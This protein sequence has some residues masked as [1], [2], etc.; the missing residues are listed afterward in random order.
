M[1]SYRWQA[2]RRQDQ[3]GAALL[4]TISFM[5]LAVL[6]L[7]LVVDTGR[8]YVEKRKLQRV[9]D[10]ATIEAN[11]RNG[12]CTDGTALTY[13][14]Q[15]ATRNGYSTNG[16][17]TITVTCGVLTTVA[18]VRTVQPPTGTQVNN[19]IK[20]VVTNN[21]RASLIAGG[22]VGNSIVMTATSIGTRDSPLAALTIKSTLATISS[23]QAGLLNSLFSGLLGGAVNVSVLGYQGLVGTQIN[24]FDF[25]GALKTSLGITAGGYDQV[26]AANV[27]AGQ[28]LNAA[29]TVLTAGGT[30]ASTTLSALNTISTAASVAPV[31]VQLGNLLGV[32]TGLPT[33]AAN[34]TMNLMDLVQG[35]VQLSNGS[36]ALAANFPIT[37][38]GI[39]SATVTVKVLQPPMLSAIGNPALAV[40]GL[41]STPRTN[42]IYVRTAQ[43]RTLVSLDLPLAG[44]I[45]N[46]TTLLTNVLSPV[47][48][49]INSILSG[50]L[51]SNLLC[52]LI[53][54]CHQQVTA[55]Q[56]LPTGRLDINIDVGGGSS[57]VSNY[58]C[59]SSS[60][61]TLTAPVTT[62]AATLRLGQMG[63]TDAAAAANAFASQS[64]PTVIP[65]NLVKL[66]YYN[67]QQ[68]CLLY[69]I[70][71]A[72]QYQQ[73]NGSYAS[74]IDPNAMVVQLGLGIMANVPVAGNNSTFTFTNPPEVTT[75]VQS[76][77]FQSLSSTN[78]FSSLTNSVNGLTINVYNSSNAGVLSSLITGVVTTTISTL[79]TALTNVIIPILS[80]LLD[81]VINQVLAQLGLDL[82]QTQ[83]AGQLS[84][85]SASGISLVY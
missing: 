57:Y 23:N 10:L 83:V 48:S 35:T 36:S 58:N 14:T 72:P 76:T 66:G 11:S 59:S 21:V 67:T 70:C 6:T 77:D 50:N 29:T 45:S 64:P 2:L 54:T 47:T 37:L 82:S 7:T 71:S 65:T 43:V 81:Q 68:T 9:A 15:S 85:S 80:T 4:M 28:I 38:P 40:A 55:L 26:L 24:L 53:G 18:G 46:L 3:R 52:G 62:A 16:G 33:S 32:Q 61:K 56:A 13:A 49:L 63:T 74:T 27:T 39:A 30:T 69:L 51:V 25:L 19:A 75:P 41:S 1:N 34:V 12:L 31:T 17:G 5:F 20:V 78:L 42:Q 84:C 73:S 44:L 79:T 22:L 8:L 60:T